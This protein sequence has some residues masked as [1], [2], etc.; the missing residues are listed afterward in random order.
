MRPHLALMSLAMFTSVAGCASS[1]L[2]M[3]YRSYAVDDPEDMA[4]FEADAAAL[5]VQPAV[6]Q[7][8][9]LARTHP[10]IHHPI[11]PDESVDLSPFPE[12]AMPAATRLLLKK[13]PR[14]SLVHLIANDSAHKWVG[15][16]ESVDSEHVV[17]NDCLFH[18]FVA[19]PDGESQG[20]LSF[21]RSKS[22]E[23]APLTH[24]RVF[25]V[26]S[27][28][29]EAELQC[30]R[31][32]GDDVAGFA[33]YGGRTV[34]VSAVQPARTASMQLPSQIDPGSR[35]GWRDP[36]GAC[37]QGTLINVENDEVSLR[38]CVCR[39]TGRGPKGEQQTKT[40]LVHCE[41]G[42]ASALTDLVVIWPPAPDFKTSEDDEDC[43]GHCLQGIVLQS[44]RRVNARLPS[45]DDMNER[46][47]ARP[48]SSAV[49]AARR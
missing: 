39:S 12:T 22:I 19:G 14:G 46:K 18:E 5:V 17:L 26:P 48:A 24:M 21:V 15:T 16:L 42:K 34:P 40:S 35:I 32:R 23:I 11:R 4:L 29:D 49:A 1:L 33:F 30:D 3:A 2:P 37:W 9:T 10:T 45:A 36:S 7:L 44:G 25:W 27:K 47:D 6:K 41:S 31:G 13:T 20:A 8:K 43:C 38:D 28:K